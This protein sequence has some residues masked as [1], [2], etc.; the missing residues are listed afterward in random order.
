LQSPD[1]QGSLHN[2][3]RAIAIARPPPGNRGSLKI[4]KLTRFRF[5]LFRIP[6]QKCKI[7][8]L[9]LIGAWLDVFFDLLEE[10]RESRKM[11]VTSGTNSESTSTSSSARVDEFDPSSHSRCDRNRDWTEQQ[12]VASPSRWPRQ[13]HGATRDFVKVCC[14]LLHSFQS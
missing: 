9:L 2:R 4:R 8:G 14:H 6:N 12:N 1:C 13:Q 3:N 7:S 10:T 11:M 5:Y